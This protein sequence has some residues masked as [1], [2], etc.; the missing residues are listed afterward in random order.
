MLM[1]EFKN[2]LILYYRMK[3]I[4]TLNFDAFQPY[5][6][7]IRNRLSIAVY[8]CRFSCCMKIR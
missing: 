4:L 8:F 5:G 1:K 2:E 6:K 3:Y 7:L